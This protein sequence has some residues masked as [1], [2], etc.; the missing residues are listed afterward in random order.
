MWKEITSNLC[1]IPE[2]YGRRGVSSCLVLTV[3]CRKIALENQVINYFRFICNT[4]DLYPRN[5]REKLREKYSAK[6]LP[7]TKLSQHIQD[8]VD[9][10]LN[11]RN[12]VVGCV[13]VRVVGSSKKYAHVKNELKR[14]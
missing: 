12:L 3:L 8:R 10:F 13:T 9:T 14:R 2:E 6:H 4:C 1:I 11:S 5:R 7:V